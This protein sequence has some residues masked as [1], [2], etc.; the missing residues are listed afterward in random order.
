MQWSEVAWKTVERLVRGVSWREMGG[1]GGTDDQYFTGP[2]K[3]KD[4][5]CNTG[6]WSFKL[7]KTLEKHTG[8]SRFAILTLL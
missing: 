7:A 3:I 8:D 1:M 2:A 5:R 6:V 4:Q